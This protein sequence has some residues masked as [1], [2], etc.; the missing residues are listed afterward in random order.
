M[1]NTTKIWLVAAALLILLGAII[2]SLVANSVGWDF[3]KL[4]TKAYETTTHNITEEFDKIS[5]KTSTADIEL[6]PS[7]DGECRVVCYEEEKI[8]YSV[9][10]EN[11]T[12][13]VNVQDT[14]KW[15]EF[16]G[17]GFNSSKITVYLP[18]AEYS[19]LTIKESTGSVKIPSDFAFESIDVSLTTGDVQCYANGARAVDIKAT[20]GNVCVENIRG[21]YLN[22]SVTTGNVTVSNASLDGDV[23]VEV[24]TGKAGLTNIVCRNLKSEGDTGDITLKNVIANEKLLIERD[25]GDVYLDSSDAAEI[26]IETDTGDVRG[27][28]LSEK[29]FNVSTDTGEREYPNTTSGG[30]C[31]ITTD[32][33]DVKITIK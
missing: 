6:S 2:F 16:I 10:V 17:I 4:S 24:S 3:T 5:I 30:R 31:E 7:P 13:T 14:R 8:E 20:T 18:D 15:Y 33:G 23:S 28:L 26:F 25:T 32:T 12:L 9:R 11:S 19:A 29:V 1:S 21:G 22:I 27:S